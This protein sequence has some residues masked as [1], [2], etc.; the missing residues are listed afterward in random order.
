MLSLRFSSG[1]VKSIFCNLLSRSITM[2]KQQDEE[3]S[4]NTD[5]MQNHLVN[6]DRCKKLKRIQGRAAFKARKNV[7]SDGGGV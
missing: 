2:F 3:A 5:S 1:L 4:L 7:V 6:H